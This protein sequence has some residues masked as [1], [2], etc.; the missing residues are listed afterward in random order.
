MR[1]LVFIRHAK[2]S[3]ENLNL[4]D[5]DRP[6]NDRG[7]ASI[8]IMGKSIASQNFKPKSILS[9]SAVRAKATAFGI[10]K[11]LGISTSEIQL[12]DELYHADVTTW[13]KIIERLPED[14]PTVFMFGHNPGITEIVEYLSSSSIGNMPTCGCAHITFNVKSWDMIS[15]GTGDLKW[16]DYPKNHQ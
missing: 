2:S 10:C 3:W 15:G 12:L 9:S 11:E 13:I 8:P 7:K 14:C 1:N 5:F 4:A 6:L 16:F